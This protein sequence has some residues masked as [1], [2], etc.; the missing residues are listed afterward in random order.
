MASAKYGYDLL[1]RH[2]NDLALHSRR[3]FKKEMTKVREVFLALSRHFAMLLEKPKSHSNNV[4][5]ALTT[6][7]ANH[8]FSAVQLI[9]RG[10]LLDAATCLR[11]ATETT[12]FYWLVD[13]DPASA[14]L[15]DAEKS[16]R[17]VEIRKKLEALGID[18]SDL[19]ERYGIESGVGHVGNRSD[20]LQIAWESNRDGVLLY[21]GGA[22]PG[23]QKL[24]LEDVQM[25]LV[26]FFRADSTYEVKQSET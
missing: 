17:P 4:K 26:N 6:R 1:L 25:Y 21:G 24:M 9:E 22:Q 23:S 8:L 7:F 13:S 19:R 15:Y 10:L 11:S 14:S 3:N 20:N 5:L 16:P 18:I 2:S 12:A